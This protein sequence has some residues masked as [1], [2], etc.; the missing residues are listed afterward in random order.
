MKRIVLLVSVL[1]LCTINSSNAKINKGPSVVCG[2]YIQCITE[3]GFTVVWVTDMDAICWVETAPDDGT[4][5][6]NCERTKHYDMRGHGMQPIGRIHK[7]RIDGLEKGSV[8]R[9][10]LMSKGVMSFKGSGDVKYTKTV[11]SDVYKGKPYEIRLLSEN[12]DT[13]RFDIYNDIHGR[14]S[15]L[16]VL[17]AERRKAV[18]FVTFNGDMTTNIESHDMVQSMYLSTAAENLGG[19]VPLFASRGNHELR[20]RDAI[21]WFDYF[22]TPTGQTY[23]SYRMGK[24]FFIVLDA[25]EDKPD[26][27]IEYAG[28]VIS[29]P[30]LKAQESWLKNTLKSEDFLSSE[31]RMVFCH[32]PPETKGWH[33]NKNVCTYFVPHLNN[34]G[35]DAMFCGH[36]HKWRYDTPD[37]GISNAAFPVICSPNAQRTEVT[38]TSDKIAVKVINSDG[39][40]TQSLELICNKK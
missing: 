25:C 33:G 16:G 8:C 4:H 14:D 23:Y 2:P 12:Y 30:Y 38:A 39:K 34:A 29:Q 40:E 28:T 17:M 36:I 19:I 1:L 20:G 32:I 18:D 11:G 27:D 5:F 15:L 22:D 24:F 6:Y 10:R 21:K 9:Y 7:I 13:L 37:S 31:I 3:T 35:I 26:S